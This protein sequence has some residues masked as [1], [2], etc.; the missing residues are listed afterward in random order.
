[1]RQRLAATG[2]LRGALFIAAALALLAGF[3]R[4]GGGLL[5]IAVGLFAVALLQAVRV[6]RSTR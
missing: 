6:Q 3:Q 2:A 1:M 4:L 5:L